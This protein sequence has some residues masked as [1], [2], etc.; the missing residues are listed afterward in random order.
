MNP[1]PINVNVNLKQKQKIND[2]EFLLSE[3]MKVASKANFVEQ[4]ERFM[5]FQKDQATR[6]GNYQSPVLQSKFLP[7]ILVVTTTTR[8]PIGP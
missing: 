4:I 3:F 8:C 1:M 7:Y 6:I 5:L 2:R